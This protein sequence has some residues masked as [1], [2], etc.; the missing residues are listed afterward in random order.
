MLAA[1]VQVAVGK[2]E[3]RHAEHAFG[4]GGVL[5]GFQ[6]A[7]ALACR[8]GARSPLRRR[9]LGSARRR[10]RLDPRCRG[11]ASRSARTPRRYRRGRR[12]AAWRRAARCRPATNSRSCACRGWSSPTRLASAPHVHVAVFD[13]TP[14]MGVA[15]LL[16][17][18]ALGVDL[19][20]AEIGGDVE[21]VGQPVDRHAG[22]ALEPSRRGPWRDRRRG[23]CS[24][25]RASGWARGMSGSLESGALGLRHSHR[26]R[27]SSRPRAARS[28][29]SCPDS[30]HREGLDEHHVARQ[31]E[32]RDLAAAV[33][34]H[35]LG[36]DLRLRLA[37]DV[38]DRNLAQAFIR[39]GRPRRPAAR[40]DAPAA[41]PRS[42]SDRRSR[43]PPSA[44]PCSGRG[45]A[46][47]RWPATSPHRRCGTSRRR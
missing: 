2:N 41:G 40:R 5:H 38:G 35:A 46:G 1:P 8:E 34:Q 17:D 45:S 14:L 20:A 36:V 3:A 11:R 33:G 21:D 9:R 25:C 44:C 6:F 12:R 42:P 29:G 13:A 16:Q 39:A 37:L 47:S 15:V 28:C 23:S 19:G 26:E 30:G 22:L 32:A 27:A 7:R 4:L 10:G 43:R 31:L 18:A 24:R